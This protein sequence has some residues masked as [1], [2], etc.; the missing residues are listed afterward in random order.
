MLHSSVPSSAKLLVLTVGIGLLGASTAH[1][2]F[3]DDLFRR[4]AAPVRQVEPESS[5][6]HV[7]VSKKARAKKKAAVLTAPPVILQK[8]TLDSSKD[9]H[10]YL[11]DETLRRGDLVVLPDRVLMFRDKKSARGPGAFEDIRKS[12]SLSKRERTRIL[13]MTQIHVGPALK[14]Q[15]VSEPTA[16]VT[17]T[18]NQLDRSTITVILP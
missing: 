2:G 15:I 3:L 6:L 14:Y 10:W 7:T 5:P 8:S 13:A 9:P 11:K 17:T 12:A 4:P 18:M 16:S 1:A